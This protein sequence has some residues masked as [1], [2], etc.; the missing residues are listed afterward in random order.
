MAEATTTRNGAPAGGWRG[1]APPEE[2]RH[3][4][5]QAGRAANGG[6]ARGQRRLRVAILFGAAAV[7]LGVLVWYL[8]YAPVQTPL[9]AVAAT[10]YEWPL[11][12]NAFASED[13]A[14]FADLDGKTLRAS[15]LS[16]EWR[17]AERGL[18]KLDAEL[19]RLAAR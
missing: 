11:V 13:L 1:A 18:E 2:P 10:Q 15:D 17:T 8:L 16:A 12:P 3:R 14:G 6:G 9:V 5:Q 19:K 7:L 4:W